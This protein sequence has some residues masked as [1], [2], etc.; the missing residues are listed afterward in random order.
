MSEQELYE[1]A[2]KRVL[3]RNRRWMFWTLDLFV[4]IIA[5]VALIVSGGNILF[6]AGFLTWGAIF[7]T[8]TIILGFTE[9]TD[10]SIENEV[11]KLRKAYE[12]EY[13]KPK[14]L[15]LGEDGELTDVDEREQDD[16]ERSRNPARG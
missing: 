12:R 4:L 6:V 15:E 3:R 16:A 13:E 2:R 8:H 1:I 14:R 11:V 7:T 5:L 9:S 10:E